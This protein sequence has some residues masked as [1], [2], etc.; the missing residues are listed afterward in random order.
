MFVFSCFQQRK[1]KQE[2]KFK[3]ARLFLS[4]RVFL[5]N[6]KRKQQIKSKKS[7]SHDLREREKVI[8]G[9]EM[10]ET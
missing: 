10:D 9:N 2:Q 1:K 8:N 7:L 3:L 4:P 6:G 5:E